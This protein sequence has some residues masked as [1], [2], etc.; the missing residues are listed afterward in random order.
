MSNGGVFVIHC[1]I[2]MVEKLTKGEGK[3][4]SRPLYAVIWEISSPLTGVSSGK[5]SGQDHLMVAV[6]GL[7]SYELWE[8][9]MKLMK[10]QG[11][12]WWEAKV[13][14]LAY[15]ASPAAWTPA[16]G[17]IQAAANGWG[18]GVTAIHVP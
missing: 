16:A 18:G 11:P 2:S 17:A 7:S 9:E 8:E 1:S 5:Y 4:V 10:H 12:R 6:N 3:R 15:W 14:I 13:P